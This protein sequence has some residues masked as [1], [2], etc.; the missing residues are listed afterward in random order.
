MTKSLSVIIPC[1]NAESFIYK[2][3]IK[4]NKRLKNLK[5]KFEIIVI[6]DGSK[7]NTLREL[8]R[9]KKRLKSVKCVHYKRNKGKSYVIKKNIN[10]TKFNN[11]VLVDC[12][13]PYF[14]VFRTVVNKLLAGYDLVIVNRRHKK[15]RVQKGSIHAYQIIRHFIGNIIGK[16]SCFLLNIDIFGSDTQAG[17]KGIRKFPKFKNLHFISEKFFLDL[18]II[19]HYLKMKKKIFSVPV[20]FKIPKKSSIKIFSLKNF[21]IFNELMRVIIALNFSNKNLHLLRKSK[22]KNTIIKNF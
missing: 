4:L 3:V 6:N 20:I 1:L 13:L 21:E 15:S 2:K 12:D 8:L 14:Q 18:E 19:Y 16:L 11:V 9:L 10:K 7:D 17:L 22:N 5:T